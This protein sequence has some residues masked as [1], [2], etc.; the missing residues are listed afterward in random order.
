MIVPDIDLLVYA[1]DENAARH[2]DAR[3]WW[4]G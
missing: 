3:R 4:E 1:H 2:E